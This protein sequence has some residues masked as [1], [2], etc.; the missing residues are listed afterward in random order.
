MPSIPF[1][2]ASLAS[3]LHI[4]P[5]ANTGSPESCFIVGTISQPI[6]LFLCN[7]TNSA[8]PDPPYDLIVV[9]AY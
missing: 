1:S 2:I 9:S 6:S 4:T 3:S 7:F 5:F 8:S